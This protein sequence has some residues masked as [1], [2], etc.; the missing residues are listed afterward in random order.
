MTNTSTD[1]PN[2]DGFPW[3]RYG[4]VES[5]D[6]YFEDR[7]LDCDI[8]DLTVW[9]LSVSQALEIAA[10]FD[11][12]RIAWRDSGILTIYGVHPGTAKWF[13]P[14]F[15]DFLARHKIPL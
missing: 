13:G 15:N 14:W 1:E 3:H 6:G 11:D 4:W 2:D 5:P 12:R 10:L 7:E 8:A 9:K